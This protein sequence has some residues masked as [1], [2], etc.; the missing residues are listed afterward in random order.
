MTHLVLLPGM[1]GT[2]DLFEPFI[3]ALCLEISVT[4]VRYPLREPLGYDALETL[5]YQALPENEPF[6][7]V[8]ESFSGP[9]AAAIAGRRPPMLKGLVLCCSFVKAPYPTLVGLKPFVPL[10]SPNL[11]PEAI[12]RWLLLGCWATPGL[13]VVLMGAIRKVSPSVWR[14]R[15]RDVLLVDE[16]AALKHAPIPVLYLRGANDRL[17]PRSASG[18]ILQVRPD[19]RIADFTAPHALLQTVP[20]EAAACIEAFAETVLLP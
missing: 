7:L 2:G 5:V 17:M 8:G 13:S 16:T 11:L 6:V 1:D 18:L 4:V 14:K 10:F 20:Q 3:A 19:V 9:I 15:I 12:L